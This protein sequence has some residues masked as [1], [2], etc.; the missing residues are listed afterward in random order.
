MRECA[1]PGRA[2]VSGVDAASS[3]QLVSKSNYDIRYTISHCRVTFI[4]VGLSRL[5][6]LY[7]PVGGLPRYAN[8]CYL[9]SQPIAVGC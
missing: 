2:P 3:E 8:R 4:P 7:Q 5:I 6:F 1:S 9:N